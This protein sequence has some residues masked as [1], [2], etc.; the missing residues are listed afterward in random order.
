MMFL[1][2]YNKW[3]TTHMS[4]EG[5]MANNCLMPAMP[6]W[7]SGSQ[8]PGTPA[9]FPG[10]RALWTK[11]RALWRVTIFLLASGLV[12]SSGGWRDPCLTS[13]LPL[14]TA[15]YPNT[16]LWSPASVSLYRY[17]ATYPIR[18]L[19]EWKNITDGKW[20]LI[21]KMLQKHWLLLL[22]V[23]SFCYTERKFVYLILTAPNPHSL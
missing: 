9:A 1:H 4:S 2:S 14:T 22:L 19:W 21:Y 5:R 7:S 17:R 12:V 23:I 16:V 11:V 10:L 6:H 20:L 8:T 3:K 15:S 18:S 13:L